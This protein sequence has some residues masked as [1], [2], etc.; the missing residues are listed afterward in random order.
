M[1]WLR[2]ILGLKPRP[3]LLQLYFRRFDGRGVDVSCCGCG[4]CKNYF[5]VQSV[6]LEKPSFCPYCG[7][8]FRGTRAISGEQMNAL[9]IF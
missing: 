9:Q 5:W 6:E 7:I 3:E 4:T 2:K 1:N 8:K